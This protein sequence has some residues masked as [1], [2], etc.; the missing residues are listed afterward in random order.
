MG[1]PTRVSLQWLEPGTLVSRPEVG[2]PLDVLAVSGDA[3][4]RS[5][6]LG[7]RT[8]GPPAR[9]E[10]RS[11]RPAMGASPAHRAPRSDPVSQSVESTTASGGAMGAARR[12]CRVSG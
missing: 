12:R 6:R 8:L 11:G 2:I 1:P 10:P 5:T 3:D 7:Y 4:G 9:R